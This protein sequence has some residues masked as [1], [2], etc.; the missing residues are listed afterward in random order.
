[1]CR[2]FHFSLKMKRLT[3]PRSATSL[4]VPREPKNSSQN[5]LGNIWLWLLVLTGSSDRW[6]YLQPF[7]LKSG[8]HFSFW[9][10]NRVFSFNVAKKK[11]AE[12]TRLNRILNFVEVGLPAVDKYSCNIF[13]HQIDKTFCRIRQLSWYILVCQNG[14]IIQTRVT[15]ETSYSIFSHFSLIQNL[16]KPVKKRIPLKRPSR[17]VLK[18]RVVNWKLLPHRLEV[19]HLTRYPH[20]LHLRRVFAQ[21][22]FDWGLGIYGE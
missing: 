11:Y 9:V 15:V 4:I 10:Q 3:T 5:Q 18:K 2:C 6:E 19:E 14:L 8:C 17:I 20:S 12:N 21:A 22:P 16:G 13:G 1:M 7:K